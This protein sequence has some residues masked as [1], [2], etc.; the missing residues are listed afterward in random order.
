M[1]EQATLQPWQWEEA[2]DY[3]GDDTLCLELLEVMGVPLMV[4]ESFEQPKRTKTGKISKSKAVVQ[5]YVAVF[6]FEDQLHTTLPFKSENM[7]IACALWYVLS[8]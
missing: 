3:V 7:A 8:K 6:D 1:N 4:L 5:K 2:P